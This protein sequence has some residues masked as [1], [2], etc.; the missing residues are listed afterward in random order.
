MQLKKTKQKQISLQKRNDN[1][2]D[3]K[4]ERQN[5]KK[6]SN[7]KRFYLFGNIF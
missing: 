2:N 4:R 6:Y 5:N 1:R 3:K 7:P